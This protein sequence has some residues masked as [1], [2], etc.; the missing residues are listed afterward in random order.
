MKKGN[1]LNKTTID[2]FSLLYKEL[3]EKNQKAWG[4]N[5][6]N[7]SSWKW[8]EGWEL[9]SSVGIRVF[10][11]Q[12]ITVPVFVKSQLSFFSPKPIT[13]LALGSC[14]SPTAGSLP[15][16]EK[17]IS[18]ICFL[19]Q[20]TACHCCHAGCCCG[21]QAPQVGMTIGCF[22]LLEG[23]MIP[24]CTIGGSLQGGGFHIRYISGPGSWVWNALH[25]QQHEFTIY[26]WAT[27]EGNNSSL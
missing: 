17:P 20:D 12:M 10:R 27:G 13:S 11:T 5:G 6:R 23:W 1:K 15:Q 18:P 16:V 4:K 2:C 9:H 26:L 21:S 19:P 22:P 7:P 14:L 8:E 3:L 25:L 24:F